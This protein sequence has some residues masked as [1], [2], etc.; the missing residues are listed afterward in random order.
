VQQEWIAVYDSSSAQ[1]N[2][3]IALDS[4][5]NIIVA[6]TIYSS[7]TNSN[8]CTIKY[9]SSGVQQWSSI[10][11]GPGSNGIDNLNAVGVDAQGN[12]CVTGYSER[13]GY[14]SDDYCT[15]K[16]N[17]NGVQQWVARYNSGSGSTNDALALAIDNSGNIYVTGQSTNNSGVF[18]I[19]T[20]KYNSNGDS[21]WVRRYISPYNMD[22][23]GVSITADNSGNVYVVGKVNF[24]FNAHNVV[25]IKYNTSGVQQW[26]IIGVQGYPCKICL[27]ANNNVII[28]GYEQI[29]TMIDYLTI[30]YN[31]SGVQQWKTNYNYIGTNYSYDYGNDL[32]IDN[33]NNIYITGRS[34]GGVTGWDY[35]TIKYNQSGIQQ[36]IQRYNGLGN[37]YDEA[38]KIIFDSAGSVYVTGRTLGNG[39]G[40]DYTTIKYNTNGI[41][42]WMINYN[43]YTSGDD[44]ATSIVKDKENN[45]IVTGTSYIGFS[46]IKYSQLLKILPITTK[47]P[48]EFTLYSNFPNPFNPSTKI[49]FTLPQK[50]FVKLKIYNSQGIEI[51]TLLNEEVNQGVYEMVFNNEKISSGIYFYKLTAM[52]NKNSFSETKK[53]V[54]LK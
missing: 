5:N 10:F 22:D 9:S 12:I 32:T 42:Q 21:I 41:Q 11:I 48:K 34:N 52:N 40:Y 33:Q 24:Q 27:D 8:Y 43:G 46:T 26:A 3:V 53:M 30:K 17:L 31:N 7:S 29:G 14:L 45:I 18:N 19:V 13:G 20:I 4:S 50:S 25:T 1:G 38:K 6:G 16:Y 39:T 47:I 49:K 44:I 28:G 35:A 37:G 51:E 2:P 15:V 36:W 54:L 23:A